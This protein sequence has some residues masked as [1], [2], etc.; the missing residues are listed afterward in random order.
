MLPKIRISR[1][2]HSYP[3][4]RGGT[5]PGRRH[6]T[7]V[8][9][10]A[11][12]VAAATVGGLAAPVTASA[13]VGSTVTPAV[14]PTAAPLR[15]LASARGLLIGAAVAVDHLNNEASYRTTLNRE[16]NAVTPE[17]AMKWDATEPN[18]GQFNFS[19]ADQIV[20]SAQQN[21]QTI[22]GHTL[23]WH[24]QLPGWVS[25]LDANN[26]RSA[27]QNH[28]QT[29][30]G[31]YAGRLDAWD[32]VNEA[33][34]ENGS[35]RQSP[36]Q[37][38]L[39]DG[40]IAEAFRM[41]KAA[42]PTAKLYYNDYNIEGINAKSD[43]VYNLVRSLKEQG[44]PIDGV[45]LQSH[46]I[47]NQVPG[48]LRQN[49]ERFAALGVDVAITELDIRI[50]MPADS[51]ELAQQASNFRTVVDACRAVSRCREIKVWGITDKYSWVPNVF[52]GYGAPLLFDD[53]YAAKPAV[54][55]VAQGLS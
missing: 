33:F 3:K 52:P 4:A 51:N 1:N 35:R 19:G 39:G 55:A 32:V 7:R 18:R 29:V 53:N 2:H 30:A 38:R 16:F 40:Y 25:G 24:S 28:I 10:I 8:A 42:D 37:Q 13:E 27:M 23:V 12:A 48:N 36:F 21:G 6:L 46:F 14:A 43:A 47:L 9:T 22:R 31:R 41:A 49:I 34:E 26:L 20:N 5:S 45:G 54:E 50:Q 15:D 11:T 17:N 44:V